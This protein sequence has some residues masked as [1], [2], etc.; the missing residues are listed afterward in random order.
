MFKFLRGGPLLVKIKCDLKYLHV[1]S[2]WMDY[3]SE[4]LSCKSG[5]VKFY[6]ILNA[7]R[8]TLAVIFKITA[9]DAPLVKGFQNLE[10]ILPL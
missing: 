9:S 5:C 7:R 8:G 3:F 4:G 2:N 10:V 6:R 1:L